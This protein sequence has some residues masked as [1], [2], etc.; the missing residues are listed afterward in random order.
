MATTKAP[1]TSG[2]TLGNGFNSY[3]Q[4]TCLNK[5]VTIT[6]GQPLS[7]Q[8]KVPQKVSYTKKLIQSLSEVTSSLNVSGSIAIKYGPFAG[9]GSGLYVD[10][11]KFSQSDLN[12]LIQVDVQ[13]EHVPTGPPD[14]KFNKLANVTLGNF[15]SIYGDT[16]I[17]DIETGGTFQAVVSIQIIDNSSK[18]D[19]E[20]Q[21]NIAFSGAEGGVDADGKVK[22]AKENLNKSTNMTISVLWHGGGEI[23]Q[24]D[25]AWDI[26]QLTQA[27]ARFPSLCADTPSQSFVLLRKYADLD[28][29]QEQVKDISPLS[30]ENA[31]LFTNNL[32]DDFIRYKQILRELS[33]TIDG[34]AKRTLEFDTS[35][36]P[37]GAEQPFVASL[38]AKGGL[39]DA[40]ADLLF[41][42]TAINT[43]VDDITADPDIVKKFTPESPRAYMDPIRWQLRLPPTRPKATAKEPKIVI[44]GKPAVVA[45]PNDKH[46]VFAQG[47][48]GFL[49]HK[50]ITPQGQHPEAIEI[51]S[52]EGDNIVLHSNC[53]PV[54]GTT[55]KDENAI[56]YCFVIGADSNLY[57]KAAA[58]GDDKWTTLQ[59]LEV[60][61][62]V[63]L[64]GALAACTYSD[65]N[66]IG[67]AVL[68]VNGLMYWTSTKQNEA[69]APLT[70]LTG[71][72]FRGIP[73]LVINGADGTLNMFAMN[74]DRNIVYNFLPANAADWTGWQVNPATFLLGDEI[75]VTWPAY[76]NDTAKIELY[77]VGEERN[78]IYIVT[79]RLGKWFTDAMTLAKDWVRAPPAVI[80]MGANHKETF[81][82]GP[83]GALWQTTFNSAAQITDEVHGWKII[84]GDQFRPMV[85]VV[86]PFGSNE[87]VVYMV[88][89]KGKLVRL[90]SSGGDFGGVDEL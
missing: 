73:S 47:S 50:L 31:A 52:Y 60:A 15:N 32:L 9:S 62:G 70:P 55:G 19:I 85:P 82:V 61:K 90:I 64:N 72:A 54:C 16:Y 41:Q 89:A 39:V 23:K 29:F 87:L 17:F 58:A 1:F 46:D 78:M 38:A 8:P 34:I 27:G 57:F 80:S 76:P 67:L 68:D 71:G 44:R 59:P 4:T 77:C 66:R 49:W 84:S 45:S 5:A 63:A 51:W 36:L 22:K 7:G 33:S 79:T 18:T 83:T 25:A 53:S 81:V 30:Y 24:P 69:W 11:S 12:F 88:N 6:P 21:A 43:V 2:M 42:T 75:S 13:N 37:S 35:A 14:E 20:A 74:T 65:P 28:S 3:T 26:D 40:K 56:R 86:L 48:D 10:E